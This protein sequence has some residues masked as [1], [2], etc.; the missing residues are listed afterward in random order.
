[1][2][3]PPAGRTP[4]RMFEMSVSTLKRSTRPKTTSNTCIARSA[5]AMKMFTTEASLIPTMFSVQS[6]TIMA[7]P[8][9]ISG[10][11]A[12]GLP[13]DPQVVGREERADRYGN[14]IVQAERPPT[15]EAGEFV[16]RVASEVR[17]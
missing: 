11:A 6:I 15:D 5:K 2:I 3:S 10:V 14:D 17:R 7:M 16:E 13:E 8:P 9:T 1:M 4:Q 12:Q